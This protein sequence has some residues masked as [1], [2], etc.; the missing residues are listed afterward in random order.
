MYHEAL[1]SNLLFLDQLLHFR[2]FNAEKISSLDSSYRLAD[3]PQNYDFDKND[4]IGMAESPKKW[5]HYRSD[6]SRFR[7]QTEYYQAMKV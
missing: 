4:N 1:S 5:A 6:L 3:L 7:L 2:L